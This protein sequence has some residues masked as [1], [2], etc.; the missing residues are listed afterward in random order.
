MW[1]SGMLRPGLTE[2][3]PPA[4]LLL[5]DYVPAGGEDVPFRDL[6]ESAA[7]YLP[8]REAMDGSVSAILEEMTVGAFIAA[9]GGLVNSSKIICAGVNGSGLGFKGRILE[10]GAGTCKLSAHLS[11]LPQV[12]ELH[13]VEFSADLLLKIAPRI[14]GLYGGDLSKF[15]FLR[16]DM[17]RVDDWPGDYDAIVSYGA[18][19]H[20]ALPDHF[21]SRILGKLKP[22]GTVFCMHEPT[23]PS[24]PLATRR[25]R[26]VLFSLHESRA[27]GINENVYSRQEYERML[28]RSFDVRLVSHNRFSGFRRYAF[29]LG[30]H[31]FWDDLYMTDIIARRSA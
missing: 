10:F 8:E 26:K 20:L 11:R 3:L 23:R 17:N 9:R 21:F 5:K 1:S 29:A 22:G 19:H 7:N 6:L 16:G 25:W 15:L 12:E 31:A 18:V 4:S 28:G 30:G 27:Q 24:W 13:C 2:P 14:I